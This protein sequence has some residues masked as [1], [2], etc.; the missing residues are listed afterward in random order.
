METKMES[1]PTIP[2]KMG[3]IKPDCDKKPP[4]NLRSGQIQ[5]ARYFAVGL[6]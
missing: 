6:G 4:R 1:C 2:E 5:T 3:F